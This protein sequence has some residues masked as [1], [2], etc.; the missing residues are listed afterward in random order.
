MRSLVRSLLLATSLFTLASCAEKTSLPVEG[1]SQSMT[2]EGYKRYGVESGIIV[3]EKTGYQTGTETV[4]FDQWG[5][6]EAR[7]DDSEI[8]AE[9]ETVK[10]NQLIL[11]D[12][13][14]TYNIDLNTKEGTKL[15]NSSY[16]EIA[17]Q[18]GSKD[19]ATLGESMLQSLGG[20]KTGTEVIAGKECD[21]WLL[22]SLG[23]VNCIWN[24]IPLKTE[25]TLGDI[26]VSGIAT[27]VQEGGPISED[28]FK[29]P[30]GI[31]LSEEN[32]MFDP[33]TLQ[34]MED[35]MPLEEEMQPE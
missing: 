5:M 22:E 9:G 16:A 25:V 20:K 34:E 15:K 31:T 33:E 12:G 23:S 6:R 11:L 27:S 8:T 14:W 21:V 2:Q 30:A 4:Y 18:S 13:E 24:S 17:E 10:T 29:V 26:Q 7:Y 3:Y 1:N 35:S 28:K 19:M 32:Q